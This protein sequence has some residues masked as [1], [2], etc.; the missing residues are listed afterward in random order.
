[1]RSTKAQRC[2]SG[3]LVTVLIVLAGACGGSDRDAV[4]SSSSRDLPESGGVDALSAACTEVHSGHSAMMWNPTMADEMLD[5]DCGW[6]YEPFLVDLDGGTDDEALTAP[7][8][9]TRYDE[10]WSIISA[11]GVGVCSVGTELDGTEQGRA[12]GFTYLL[13]APGCPG[14]RSTGALHVGEFGT[15]AQRDSAAHSSADH[16]DETFVLG[17]WVVTL[18]GDTADVANGLLELGGQPVR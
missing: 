10:L 8:Q 13:G 7:F 16:G 4:A 14:A 1:M 5:A 15:E 6:P 2:R 18:E 12:F 11:S 9:A 17:R 3:A